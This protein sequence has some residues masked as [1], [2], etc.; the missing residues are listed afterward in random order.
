MYDL[1]R[2]WQQTSDLQAVDLPEAGPLDAPLV[3]ISFNQDWLPVVLGAILQLCRPAQWTGD[4]SA[5]QAAVTAA[6]LLA[7]SIGDAE[8]CPVLA[9]QCDPDTGLPQYSV[10]GGTTWI[11]LPACF[12]GAK[13]DTGDTGATGA[14]GPAGPPFV[15]QGDPPPT[16]QGGTISEQACNIASYLAAEVLQVAM[17]QNVSSY[18]SALT[19]IDAVTALFDLVPGVDVVFGLAVTAGAVLYN[20]YTSA[21]IGEFTTAS[22]DATLL[23][24]MRCA[25]YEAIRADGYVTAANFGTL[26]ANI[27][28][29]SYVDAD[30]ITALVAFLN[31]LGA[32]GLEAI[33]LNGSLYV[34]DC[35]TCA[36][37]P[38]WCYHWDFTT[39]VGPW[40]IFTGED[41]V[42]VPGVGFQSTVDTGAAAASIRIVPPDPTI[43]TVTVEFSRPSVDASS[44]S[45]AYPVVGGGG[46]PSIIDGAAFP[47]GTVQTVSVA[48]GTYDYLWIRIFQNDGSA[49]PITI[50]GVSLAGVGAN[51]YGTTNC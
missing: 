32:V 51:P 31:A 40:G 50:T 1:N 2:P 5:Q 16:P 9:F 29:I 38:R 39:D 37:P 13:G 30:V 23:A 21:S 49:L 43:D 45:F 10:D 19:L 27:G 12:K 4:D 24:D 42:Y 11:D 18:N 47:L 48:P 41:G 26:V 25:I 3:C 33:Q 35:S 22:T 17:A 6:T 46:T 14:T 8:V 28:A 36:D 20:Y 44:L 7:L 15:G 34:G